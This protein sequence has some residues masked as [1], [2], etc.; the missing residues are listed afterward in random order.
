MSLVFLSEKSSGKS[1]KK[2]SRSLGAIMMI[3]VCLNSCS[4]PQKSKNATII[5]VPT[6]D[7]VLH[8]EGFL[9]FKDAP[10]FDDYLN[11]FYEK[12]QLRLNDFVALAQKDETARARYGVLAELFNTQG[13]LAVGE[14]LFLLQE[15]KI[16]KK[17]LHALAESPTFVRELIDLG[18]LNAMG[19]I[20]VCNA[21]A[22]L[23]QPQMRWGAQT[24]LGK[25][26][27]EITHFITE[28]RAEFEES[29]Q[30]IAQNKALLLQWQST[31]TEDE[32]A[33]AN[34]L[35][36]L[37]N[38]PQQLQ[39]A[40]AMDQKVVKNP[41]T[42]RFFDATTE[43]KH[44]GLVIKNNY[45]RIDP[46]TSTVVTL[47]SVVAPPVISLFSKPKPPT[48]SLSGADVLALVNA[49]EQH[50]LAVTALWI[51]ATQN[52]VDAFNATLQMAI[53]NMFTTTQML[54]NL[55]GDL[56]TVTSIS[57]TGTNTT[58]E[59][60]QGGAQSALIL[61]SIASSGIAGTKSAQLAERFGDA[62]AFLKLEDWVEKSWSHELL[63]FEH[64][65]GYDYYYFY[66]NKSP[67]IFGADVFRFSFTPYVMRIHEEAYHQYQI[68]SATGFERFVPSFEVRYQNVLGHTFTLSSDAVRT[69][70]NQFLYPELSF[71]LQR[72][73]C[74]QYF[75]LNNEIFSSR[76]TADRKD[77]YTYEKIM[78]Q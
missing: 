44:P 36:G 14:E 26:A 70:K 22:Q 15:G 17:P 49:I 71:D 28:N 55:L 50:N 77:T 23:A 34:F 32:K 5:N 19:G 24:H 53:T 48:S 75:R 51:E 7:Y 18:A 38:L 45:Q 58:T 69:Q 57:P 78:V 65:Q 2:W 29:L 61:A 11:K 76:I 41:N 13:A 16:F 62:I 37:E 33:A 54:I 30:Y 59:L 47:V 63:P 56:L 10:T 8:S 21:N 43:Q 39:T 27:E 31:G 4:K 60:V 40:Q 42:Q 35:L 6:A 74:L 3:S 25:A 72:G 52:M 64:S 9:H 46:I 66:F 12:P 67:Y 68:L 20:P 73:A 1:C